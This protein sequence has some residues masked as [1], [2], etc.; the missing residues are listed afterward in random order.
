MK[1]TTT[2]LRLNRQTIKPLSPNQLTKAAGG[3]TGYRCNGS[4]DCS[5]G[6]HNGTITCGCTTDTGDC[7]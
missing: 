1:K 4:W 2:A 6:C 5:D 3:L 7:V